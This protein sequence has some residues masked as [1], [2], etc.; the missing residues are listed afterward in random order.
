MHPK[1]FHIYG[2]LFIN[3]YGVAIAVGLL[4]LVWRTSCDR[5]LKKY[6]SADQYYEL[7]MLGI[8]SGVIGGRA[9]YLATNWDDLN[10]WSEFFAIWQ[11]GLSILGVILSVFITSC[12]YLR[13][14]G[15]PLFKVTDR[16]AIYAPL[17]QAF[18]RIG[19]FVAGCCYGTL[20][21][22][23]WAVTYTHHDVFAPLYVPLHPTQLYS[24]LLFFLIFIF[25][26]CIAKSKKL[27]TGELTFLYLLLAGL[28]RFLL[29][30]WRGDRTF[31]AAELSGLSVHQLLSGGI[32]IMAL[33]ALIVNK[34]VKQR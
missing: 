25:L 15:I 17:V 34:L 20:C 4:I 19:C 1:L 21:N 16:F 10:H 18:G 12:A 7:I 6:L 26:Y 14:H 8:C 9:L 13:L 32:V 33:L 5:A 29:D 22:Q 2:S 30:F 24:A 3:S 31:F 27:E 23:P 28:E 11:G